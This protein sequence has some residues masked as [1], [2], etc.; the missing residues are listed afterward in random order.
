MKASDQFLWCPKLTDQRIFKIGL[1]LKSCLMHPY[2]GNVLILGFPST[3]CILVPQ[4][5]KL[6]KV[7]IWNCLSSIF[8][9][10]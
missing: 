7:K 8:K 2:F 3:L 9:N 10:K 4:L 5:L 6:W 1:A